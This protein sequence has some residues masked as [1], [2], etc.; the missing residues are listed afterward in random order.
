VSESADQARTR[1]RWISLA[2]FVAV[3]GLII[4]ALGFWNS[5]SE[6][7]DAQADRAQAAQ[8]AAKKS[9]YVLKGEVA[10]DK[11]VKLTRDENHPLSEARVSFPKALGVG[12][13]DALADSINADWFAKPLLKL[14]DGGPDDRTG[15]LP[16][17]IT[18][19][20]NDADGEH[21][22]SGIYDVIWQTRPGTL[23]LQGRRLTI[24]NFRLRHAGGSQAELDR[25]WT[26]P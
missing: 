11:S 5:W 23:P 20:Y 12:P 19:T 8:D 13:Q 18:Y 9:R 4:A 16:V 2:E 22:A 10:S 21:R 1:R 14:T 24:A 3:A 7:R 25:L 6:R 15:R 17:L 26:R